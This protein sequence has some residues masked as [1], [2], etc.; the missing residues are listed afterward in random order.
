M[1]LFIRAIKT[2]GAAFLG[3]WVG[4]GLLILGCVI[5]ISHPAELFSPQILLVSDSLHSMIV[6]KV[7]ATSLVFFGCVCLYSGS[8]A[9][10]ANLADSALR[11]TGLSLIAVITIFA[12]VIMLLV[13]NQNFGR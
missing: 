7:F 1:L 3:I 11:I 6:M 10:N 9:E 13:L 8:H 5:L 12:V 2:V 4:V